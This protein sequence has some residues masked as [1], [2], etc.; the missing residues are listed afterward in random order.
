[1]DPPSAAAA[2]AAAPLTQSLNSTR[3]GE[4]TQG[5]T[6]PQQKEEGTTQM[7]HTV[8]F[9]NNGFTVDDGPL[10]Q[11]D[12][13]ANAPFLQSIEKV[14][15]PSPSHHG[16]HHRSSSLRVWL[17]HGIFYLFP[18]PSALVAEGHMVIHYLTDH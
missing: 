3:A 13:P 6:E 17:F 12:D 7:V 15:A 11:Q 2:K 14:R 8:T 16:P 9:Y 5:P 4:H 1:M 18:E 10:R